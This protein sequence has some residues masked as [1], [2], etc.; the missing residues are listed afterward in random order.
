M[1]GE[2]VDNVNLQAGDVVYPLAGSLPMGSPADM[3]PDWRVSVSTCRVAE[4]ERPSTR[5]RAGHGDRPEKW[6]AVRATP[7]PCRQ[8]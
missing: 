8:S 2:T 4:S 5:S 1:V 7:R 6:G 3:S